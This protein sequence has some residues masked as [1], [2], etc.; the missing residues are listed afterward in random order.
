M[1]TYD[2][3]ELLSQDDASSRPK[4]SNSKRGRKLECEDL[5]LFDETIE[6]D[7]SESTPDEEEDLEELFEFEEDDDDLY[8]ENNQPREHTFVVGDKIMTC[9]FPKRLFK[10]DYEPTSQENLLKVYYEDEWAEA[11]RRYHELLDDYYLG[12]EQAQQMQNGDN[13]VQYPF[14]EEQPTGIDRIKKRFESMVAEFDI[15]NKPALVKKSPLEIKDE[16]VFTELFDRIES[17]GVIIKSKKNISGSI[18]GNEFSYWA[19]MPFKYTHRSNY[20]EKI[21]NYYE[22][23]SKDKVCCVICSGHDLKKVIE[24]NGCAF[25]YDL[26]KRQIDESAKHL[27]VK[28]VT[29]TFEFHWFEHAIPINEPV[30]LSDSEVNQLLRFSLETQVLI[31]SV[32]GYSVLALIAPDMSENNKIKAIHIYEFNPSQSFDENNLETKSKAKSKKKKKKNNDRVT[33]HEIVKTVQKIA[34]ACF[35]SGGGCDLSQTLCL[36]VKKPYRA[37]S[38][39]SE[40]RIV[41]LDATTLRENTDTDQKKYQEMLGGYLQYADQF[42]PK[43]FP[44]PWLPLVIANDDFD[45]RFYN[46]YFREKDMYGVAEATPVLRKLYRN[47][48]VGTS[49]GDFSKL[50]EQVVAWSDEIEAKR[51]ADGT[52]RTYIQE[53]T[54]YLYAC[55]RYTAAGNE[56]LIE[57]I[58]SALYYE[59]GAK[60]DESLP[61]DDENPETESDPIMTENCAKVIEAIF[62]LVKEQKIT[63]ERNGDDPDR[64]AFLYTHKEVPCVCLG[65]NYLSDVIADVGVSNYTCEDF[66]R[67]CDEFGCLE[68]N[69][70]KDLTISVKFNKV[71]RRFTAVKLP[72][73][74]E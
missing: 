74:S 62:A 60:S 58:H 10:D 35:V 57:A 67:D 30:A 59:R 6:P 39:L 47:A 55:C 3:D 73:D 25:Q 36:D 27:Q 64:A 61:D 31:F 28:D 16:Y 38:V 45:D 32:L 66:A 18:D 49:S 24:D 5:S 43:K 69:T 13:P 29:R 63:K 68:K 40:R 52:R 34:L 42:E 56:K 14:A 65:D 9:I 7:S 70:E 72:D 19:I 11:Y 44:T 12:S 71:S 54:D 15:H 46:L 17:K 21:Y 37:I 51:N 22:I 33:S 2:F 8:D 20:Q 53:M 50:H 48:L 26:I 4:K 1:D 41:F 23:Y